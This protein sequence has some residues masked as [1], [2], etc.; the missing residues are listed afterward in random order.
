MQSKLNIIYSIN[1]IYTD[2]KYITLTYPGGTVV[3]RL[4]VVAVYLSLLNSLFISTLNS[5]T[6]DALFFNERMIYIYQ[7]LIFL[8]I[9]HICISSDSAEQ[10]QDEVHLDGSSGGATSSIEGNALDSDYLLLYIDRTSLPIGNHKG[11]YAKHRIAE[12]EA[13][14]EYRGPIIK[15]AIA[16]EMKLDNTYTWEITDPDNDSAYILGDNVCAFIND[17]V[18]ILNN[19][20]IM[21]SEFLDKWR[22]NMT[23]RDAE[24]HAPASWMPDEIKCPAGMAEN[25]MSLSV[26]RKI[27]VV[28]TRVIEPGEEL[29]LFYG[30]TYWHPRAANLFKNGNIEIC[31]G[32]VSWIKHNTP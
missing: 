5:D 32:C 8:Y 18:S 19:P 6:T 12:G 9:I 23:A 26:G 1:T 25:V 4:V 11:V 21:N 20:S 17:C 13:V 7:L 14:C 29:F 24:G 30:N 2:L 10:P 28:A 27:L 16:I 3:W 31:E 15:K 22:E